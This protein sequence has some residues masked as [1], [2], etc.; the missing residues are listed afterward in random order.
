MDLSPCG[1]TGTC[2]VTTLQPKV[3]E[4][5]EKEKLN[6]G[7]TGNFSNFGAAGV[8]GGK[9]WRSHGRRGN[10]EGGGRGCLSAPPSCRNTTPSATQTNWIYP[11]IFIQIQTVPRLHYSRL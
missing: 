7:Q 8:D 9:A 1:E 5:E 3:E 4:E 11:Q 2:G 6:T 10:T